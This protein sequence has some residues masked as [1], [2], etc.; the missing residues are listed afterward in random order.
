MPGYGILCT[1]SRTAH[2]WLQTGQQRF[3]SQQECEFSLHLYVQISSGVH[4]NSYLTDGSLYGMKGPEYEVM[5]W[6][7]GSTSLTYL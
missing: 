4:P 7:F 1:Q 5:V 6:K 3:Y 2:E